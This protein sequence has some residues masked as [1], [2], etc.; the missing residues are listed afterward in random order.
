MNTPIGQRVTGLVDLTTTQMRVIKWC[1]RTP[2]IRPTGTPLPYQA[3]MAPGPIWVFVA[4]A[5]LRPAVPVRLPVP[6][7]RRQQ[8]AVRVRVT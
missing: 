7:A 2:C 1:I 3:A 4:V 5:V 6:A 8:A